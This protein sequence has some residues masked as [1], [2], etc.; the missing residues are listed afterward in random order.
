MLL[1]PP[2]RFL[3]RHHRN[4]YQ[5]MHLLSCHYCCIVRVGV[6]LTAAWLARLILTSPHILTELGVLTGSTLPH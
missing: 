4:L 3:Y 5:P 2:A 1:D 6:V